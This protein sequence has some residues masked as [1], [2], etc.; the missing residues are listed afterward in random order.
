[1][2]ARLGQSSRK[3]ALTF[4]KDHEVAQLINQLRDVAI[5]FHDTQQLRERIT[6]LVKP[7]VDKI[8]TNV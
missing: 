4:P 2:Q 7:F 8:R 3:R 6:R 5:E 1:M